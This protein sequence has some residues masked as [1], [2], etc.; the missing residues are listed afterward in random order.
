MKKALFILSAASLLLLQACGGG[1]GDGT[2]TSSDNTAPPSSTSGDNTGASATP[3]GSDTGTGGTSATAMTDQGSVSAPFQVGAASHFIL[4]GPASFNSGSLSSSNSQQ[5]T[6]GAMTNLGGNQLSG[7]Y[8]VQDMAGDASFAI[9][10]WAEGDVTSSTG[11][12]D[13]LTGADGRAYHYIAYQSLS[14]FPTGALHC[15]G[16]DFTTPT[17][18]GGGSNAALTG[19]TS[20]AAVDIAFSGNSGALSGAMT[21][22]ANGETAAINLPNQLTSPAGMAFTSVSASG[23][24][25][26]VQLADAGNGAYALIVQFATVTPSGARYIGVGRLS[27]TSSQ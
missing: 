17:Y 5:A 12:T 22:T 19:V 6:D 9:G 13:T 23:P 15:E 10:R 25:T 8:A 2:P 18:T 7:A 1:G 21:V 26:G 16:G 3:P 24:S 11:N 20:G 4:V 27:C 14:A